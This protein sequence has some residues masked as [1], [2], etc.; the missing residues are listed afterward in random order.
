MWIRYSFP[1]QSLS[2]IQLV[3]SL[4]NYCSRYMHTVTGTFILCALCAFRS[5]A[6]KHDSA[7]ALSAH[8]A[9]I[10]ASSFIDIIQNVV[11]TAGERIHQ[12]SLEEHTLRLA[13]QHALAPLNSLSM[14][15]FSWVLEGLCLQHYNPLVIRYFS[16]SEELMYFLSGYFYMHTHFHYSGSDSIHNLIQVACSIWIVLIRPYSKCSIACS[17]HLWNICSF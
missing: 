1:E 15:W 2:R 14:S 7:S 3:S 11:N 6:Q 5:A 12:S 13:Q 8:A 4:L 10:S 17:G 16:R 9:V